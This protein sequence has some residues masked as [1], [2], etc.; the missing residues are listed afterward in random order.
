[1]QQIFTHTTSITSKWEAIHTTAQTFQPLWLWCHFALSSKLQRTGSANRT[2]KLKAIC[3]SALKNVGVGIEWLILSLLGTIPP[4]L[5]EGIFNNESTQPTWRGGQEKSLL[6]GLTCDNSLRFGTLGFFISGYLTYK[7][8]NWYFHNYYG[9]ERWI[10]ISTFENCDFIPF[11]SDTLLYLL[12]II[13]YVQDWCL[14]N[15]LTNTNQKK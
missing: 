11:N 14:R 1:M 2:F 6:S 8:W 12:F 15:A 10:K 9:E 5:T 7:N 13:V 3:S 4:C